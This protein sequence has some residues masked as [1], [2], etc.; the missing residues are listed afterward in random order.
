MDDTRTVVRTN[1]LRFSWNQISRANKVLL[2]FTTLISLLQIIVTAIILGIG[3]RQHLSCNKPL[4]MYLIIFVIRV[5]VSL[6]FAIY[7][8]LT[9][10][11]RR[12]RRRRQRRTRRTTTPP[13]SSSNS[14][15][16]N[17]DTSENHATND[18]TNASVNNTTNDDNTANDDSTTNGDNNNN[19]NGTTSNTQGANNVNGGEQRPA[20]LI[21]GWANRLATTMHY[22]KVEFTKRYLVESN[23]YWICLLFCGL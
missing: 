21:T 12:P 23:L 11:R 22:K 10:P 18:N 6:P 4:Q 2:V 16:E 15:T 1:W 8:H 13:L 17:V 19:G 20:T 5:G 7:Q 14:P 3:G 9:T